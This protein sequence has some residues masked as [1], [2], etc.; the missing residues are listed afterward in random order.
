MTNDNLKYTNTHNLIFKE[1]YH[2]K[3]KVL[4]HKENYHRKDKVL[5]GFQHGVSC[6]DNIYKFEFE[7][8]NIST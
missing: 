1:N 5:R 6:Y 2:R 4:H 3:D 7:F 8:R